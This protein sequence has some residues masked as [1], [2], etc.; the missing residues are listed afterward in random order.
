[1]LLTVIASGLMDG[2]KHSVSRQDMIS[3]TPKVGHRHRSRS[4]ES[5]N[6]VRVKRLLGSRSNLSHKSQEVRQSQATE[7][8]KSKSGTPLRSRSSLHGRSGYTPSIGSQQGSE[9]SLSSTVEA[10]AQLGRASM[11]SSTKGEGIFSSRVSH[12]S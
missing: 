2:L 3:L 1:M 9:Y 12:E 11:C 10:A 6:K 7:P 4:M 8:T 5:I